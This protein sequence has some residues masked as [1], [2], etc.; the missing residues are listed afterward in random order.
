MAFMR[1]KGSSTPP[2][3]IPC[4]MSFI[5]FGTAASDAPRLGERVRH[6][7]RGRNALRALALS[8]LPV[9]RGRED[10]ARLHH[11]LLRH[12]LH[13][14]LLY[15]GGAPPSAPPPGPATGAGAG[16]RAVNASTIILKASITARIFSSTSSARTLA[17]SS[18][19]STPIRSHASAA[20]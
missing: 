7:R 12:L 9:H 16:R 2:R 11:R 6:L 15:A 17:A 3:F 18:L 5:P 8:V 14:P 1:A 19:I 20:I 13:R 10:R 4:S